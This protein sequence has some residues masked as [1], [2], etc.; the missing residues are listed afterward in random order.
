[1]CEDSGADAL[2]LINTLLGMR[3]DL[4][5]GKP[6]LANATGGLSGP[7]IFP[8]ALRMVWQVANAV[9]IPLLGL[10]GISTPDDAREMLLA[11]AT[12]IGVGTAL[13]SD[14]LTPLKIIRELEEI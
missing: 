2:S 7:A 8:V 14:P 13:F 6:L 10:G 9:K 1:A 3:F 12:L 5:S 11:G 4:K